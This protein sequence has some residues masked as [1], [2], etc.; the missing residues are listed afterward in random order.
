MLTTARRNS[1][2]E[3][4]ASDGPPVAE[5]LVPTPIFSGYRD[6]SNGP[7]PISFAP[8]TTKF[9][10]PMAHGTLMSDFAAEP[11]VLRDRDDMFLAKNFIELVITVRADTLSSF[12]SS[13]HLYIH[14][15]PASKKSG[16]YPWRTS[17]GIGTTSL[18]QN[19]HDSSW[20]NSFCSQ[21][22]V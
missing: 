1:S 21:T 17:L 20:T 22:Y 19:W 18:A 11:R 12:P 13:T 16:R 7:S 2:P 15:G 14:S 9:A 6:R 5:D 8:A 3:G 10:T 4:V